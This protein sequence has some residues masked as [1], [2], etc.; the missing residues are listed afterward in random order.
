MIERFT[1]PV[2]GVN[3]SK[4]I[5]KNSKIFEAEILGDKK[6]YERPQEVESL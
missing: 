5:F 2:K 3:M 4:E 1:G 6:I